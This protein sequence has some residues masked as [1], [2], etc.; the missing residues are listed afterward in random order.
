MNYSD[1]IQILDGATREDYLYQYEKEDR[2]YVI[3]RAERTAIKA[4]KELLSY[5]E[6]EKKLNGISIEQVVNGFIAAIEK[7]DC[8]R[9]ER[10]RILTNE[11]ADVWNRYKEEMKKR[12]R[13]EVKNTPSKKQT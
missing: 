1:A 13:E 8:E 9:Y 2:P 3:A 7:E 5:K 6:M 12:F 11:D 10:G 4:I